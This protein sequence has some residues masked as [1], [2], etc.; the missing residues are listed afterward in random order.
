MSAAFPAWLANAV[1]YQIYPPSF[2]D[3]NGDGIGDLRGIIS[4]LDYLR[5]LGVNAVWLNPIF[6]SPFRDG[7]YDVTDFCDVAPRYG[8]LADARRLFREAKRRGIRV[9]LDLVAGHTSDQH[10]WFRAAARERRNRN[11]DYYIWTRSTWDMFA[12]PGF[13]AGGTAR[14][15]AYLPN[16]FASQPA[17]NY[18]YARP[19]P[20]KSWQQPTTA[21]GPRRVRAE[22]RR[23]M[24]FW[25]RLGCAGFRVDMASSL[26]K[27]DRDGCGNRALWRELRSWL[28]RNYPEAVLVS[29][30]GNP[31][32]AIGA[33][34][35]V[36]FLLHFGEPAYQHL[37]AP[38]VDPQR[39]LGIMPFFDAA[40]RGDVTA[41]LRNY[42][43]HV[44]AVGRRG[45]VAL[46]SGNHDFARFRFGRSERELKVFLAFL[47]T[48]PGVPFLYYGDE[49][50]L[51][52]QAGLAKEGGY[53]RTGART[54]MQWTSGRN[55]G[56]S[57]APRKKLYLPVDRVRGRDVAAQT[58]RRRSLLEHVRALIGLRRAHR[59]LGNAAAFRVVWAKKRRVPLIFQRG[60]GAAAL[61]V[62]I[63]PARRGARVRLRSSGWSLLVGQQV[64]LRGHEM[65]SGPF[66]WAV[67]RRRMTSGLNHK[68][69]E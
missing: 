39:P 53:S 40:G 12:A 27:E 55:R 67:L 38:R 6:P 10:P 34:F 8:T 21:P 29:E 15:G 20:E 46:P 30:W 45:F 63:N 68:A 54:P 19:D 41:F 18:G 5:N 44:Q 52:Y 31:R 7:G 35:H 28:E 33:G 58:G 50:G 26:V 14:D 65:A 48:M 49:I 1:F 13:I 23:I 2:A 25:L 36:D 3:A 51:D 9:C 17:L 57:S 22:L 4:R 16:F 60:E 62:V 42:L 61:L 11:S 64:R 37:C 43:L 69:R 59:G 66:S 56:F 24:A 47:L 32:A